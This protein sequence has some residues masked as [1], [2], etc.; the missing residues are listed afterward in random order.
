MTIREPVSQAEMDGLIPQLVASNVGITTIK[1]LVACGGEG[2]GFD[3]R[4]GE[5]IS[6][7]SFKSSWKR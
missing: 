1:D 2:L 7:S 6:S 3:E 5:P 4:I